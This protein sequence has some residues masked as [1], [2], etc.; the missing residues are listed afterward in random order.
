MKIEA[1]ISLS[2]ILALAL[3][4]ETTPLDDYVY[5]PGIYVTFSFIS[6]DLSFESIPFSASSKLKGFRNKIFSQLSK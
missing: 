5:A 2:I 3:S 4:I 1:S 6:V